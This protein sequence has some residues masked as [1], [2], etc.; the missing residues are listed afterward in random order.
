[1]AKFKVED[2]IKKYKEALKEKDASRPLFEE[3]IEYVNP[4]KNT[5]DSTGETPN[6]NTLQQDSNPLAAAVNFV[7]KMSQKFTPMFTRW[8]ELK[9]G[10]GLPVDQKAL[11]ESILGKMNDITFAYIDA[12]NYAACKAKVYFDLGVGTGCFDIVKG[13]TKNPLIF[14]DNPISSVSISQ[15]ANGFK[16]AVFVDRAIKFGDL[17][18]I[19]KTKLSISPEIKKAIEKT[20][21]KLENFIEAVYYSDEDMVWYYAVIH[22]KSKHEL[23]CEPHVE[24]PRISPRWMTIPGYSLGI[25]PFTLAL[26]DIRNLNTTRRYEMESAAMS[27]FGMYTVEGSS[28]LNPNNWNLSPGA[29]LTVERNGATPSIAP[30]P[31]AGNFQAQEYLVNGMVDRVRALMLDRRLPPEAG[32]PKTAYEISKRLEE[33][34]SDIGAALPQLIFED[35]QPTMRRIVSILQ[36]VG[37]YDVIPNLPK[38]F[39]Q[40]IDNINIQV[41]ISSPISRGQAMQDV[42]AFSQAM[43]LLQAIYPQMSQFVTKVPEVVHWVFEKAGAPKDLILGVDEIQQVVQNLQQQTSQMLAQQQSMGNR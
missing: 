2:V 9:P 30:L 6:E 15:M 17:Q 20:P 26:S 35:V 37:A 12:S 5:Y 27:T 16:D 4:F 10:P 11:V 28:A 32:Q 14:I 38:N 31:G 21:E 23:F 13:D 40:L 42:Q 19:F 18:K 34:E 36:D 25:G 29:F 8:A 43:S 22:E 39:S 7:S 3:V 24:N 41:T 1:M 33:L